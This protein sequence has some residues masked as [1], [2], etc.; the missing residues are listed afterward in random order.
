M[1]SLDSGRPPLTARGVPRRWSGALAVLVGIGLVFA[2]SLSLVLTIFV[3][4]RAHPLH[5]TKGWLATLAALF[6]VSAIPQVVLAFRVAGLP[7]EKQA[8]AVRPSLI[9]LTSLTLA[10]M[11]LIGGLYGS[12]DFHS[13]YTTYQTFRNVFMAGLIALLYAAFQTQC[14]ALD[15]GCG[16]GSL[17]SNLRRRMAHPASLVTAAIAVAIGLLTATAFITV[18][19]DDYARYWTIADALA[20]GWGYPASEV[21]TSYQAGG[22]SS[23]LVDLPGLPLLMLASFALFGHTVLA[24]MLPVLATVSL[25]TL[26]SFLAFREVTLNAAVSFVG[27]VALTLFPLLTFYVLRAGEP[28]GMFVTLLMAMAALAVK[29]DRSPRCRLTWLALGLVSA[30]VALTRPEGIMYAGVTFLTLALTNHGH[31][32]YW[33][34]TAALCSLLGTFSVT[35]LLTFGIPWPTTFAGTVQPRHIAQNL[36]GFLYWGLPRYAEALGLP[37][38]ALLVLSAGFVALF[39][40]GAGRLARRQPQLLFLALLPALNIVTFLLVSPALTRPQFPYDFFRRASYG[41]P[42]MA[43][44]VSYPVAQGLCRL[45]TQKVGQALAALLLIVSIGVVAYEGKLGAK[46]EAVHQGGTQILTSG[47]Y[48]MATD[49]LSNPYP[50]P[51]MPFE[52]DGR[53]VMVAESFDYTGFRTELTGFFTPMDL[54]GSHRA[55]DYVWTSL[56]L[57]LIGVSYALFAGNHPSDRP[58]CAEH[59]ALEGIP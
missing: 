56:A 7:A 55:M 30:L 27:S 51:V 14:A 17:L 33:L 16:S 24:A 22:M 54:H 38:P 11:L 59:Q 2:L 34:G 53:A 20:G 58:N 28:D 13:S 52:M 1:S 44:V 10:A 45:K 19:G 50:L 26:A 15:R 12:D 23:Y 31:R 6:L 47:L 25:F 32:G 48:L 21:G 57:F 39:L 43:I 40:A 41:L 49:L 9:L 42:F 37:Q 4:G 8:G 36:D 5:A 29:C 3:L 35:M 18:I 46:P